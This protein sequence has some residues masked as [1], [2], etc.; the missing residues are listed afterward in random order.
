MVHSL[1]QKITLLTQVNLKWQVLNMSNVKNVLTD[2]NVYNM[3]LL[4]K[5]FYALQAGAVL[6]AF[7]Y[8]FYRNHLIS[9]LISISALLY[10]RIKTSHI[11]RKRKNELSLQFKD[12]LYCLSSSLASGKPIEAAF[13]DTLKDLLIIYPDARTPI[14]N[15]TEI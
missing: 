10:P 9:A 3:P 15:E 11:I 12:M 1:K 2:Y 6:Y 13:K 5:L 14:I 4:H 8:L 7:G